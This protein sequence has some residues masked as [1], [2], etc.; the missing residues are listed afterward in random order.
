MDIPPK[1][2]V[3]YHK[4]QQS[5][6]KKVKNVRKLV[7]E[8]STIGQEVA[9]C[10][11]DYTE[12]QKNL[13]PLIY[14]Y[15]NKLT[16][17]K[18]KADDVANLL[19]RRRSSL[20]DLLLIPPPLVYFSVGP[21]STSSFLSLCSDDDLIVH[22]LRRLSCPDAVVVMMIVTDGCDDDSD[23]GGGCDDFWTCDF[24]EAGPIESLP[25]VGWLVSQHFYSKTAQRIFLHKCSI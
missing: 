9:Q 20:L 2:K 25:L 7:T 4:L 24:V 6:Q 8:L 22:K 10:Q 17:L 19:R 12:K 18:R 11:V 14:D 16:V 13:V 15:E 1:E 23:D 5:I 3:D 21:I